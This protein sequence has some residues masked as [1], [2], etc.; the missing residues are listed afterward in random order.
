MTSYSIARHSIT[1]DTER[2]TYL[3]E[4]GSFTGLSSSNGLVL[5]IATARCVSHV[6]LVGGRICIA[7]HCVSIW[8]DPIGEDSLFWQPLDLYRS[9]AARLKLALQLSILKG[10]WFA[11]G[12]TDLSIG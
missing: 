6:W 5:V 12:L 11:M 4:Y 10:P 9:G 1:N 3:S 8:F 2:K 7:A